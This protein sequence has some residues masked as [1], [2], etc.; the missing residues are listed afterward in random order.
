M[1]LLKCV[2][3]SDDFATPFF[4]NLFLNSG[5]TS[6][7][8]YTASVPSMTSSIRF[9]R[10]SSTNQITLSSTDFF[11]SLSIKSV[12]AAWIVRFRV[13][14]LGFV[15][16]RFWAAFRRTSWS[17]MRR[18]EVF[19][20]S[21]KR[22]ST[23]TTNLVPAF[24]HA[25]WGMKLFNCMSS[26]PRCLSTLPPRP[27]HRRRDAAFGQDADDPEFARCK[28]QHPPH[29]LHRPHQRTSMCATSSHHAYVFMF[30]SRDCFFFAVWDAAKSARFSWLWFDV[31]TFDFYARETSYENS[32][33]V[34]QSG[35][36]ALTSLVHV[37]R[38]LTPNARR[39]FLLLA[40]HQL[41]QKQTN[42]A[43]MAFAD[44]YQRCREAFLVNSDLTL[45]AQLT[46]FNDHKLLRSKR[47]SS[48]RFPT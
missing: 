17:R 24:I 30:L 33:L 40:Q 12:S 46:E 43:G 8:Y 35:I 37:M 21:A 11:P 45:R 26:A 47:V 10:N 42:Y 27:Q 6:I 5:T 44:L 18:H 7:S 25:I 20:T 13:R 34:S 41:E 2:I 39:I 23:S 16:C 29:R 9:E 22:S 38:S 36:L 3:W 14:L 28:S 4:C 48:Q 1:Q 32:L 15:V 19:R 31:T